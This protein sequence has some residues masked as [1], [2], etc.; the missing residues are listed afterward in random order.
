MKL[1]Y[2]PDTIPKDKDSA[3]KKGETRHGIGWGNK[4]IFTGGYR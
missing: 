1:A 3:G 2:I 4:I